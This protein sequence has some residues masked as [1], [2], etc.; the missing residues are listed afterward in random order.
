MIQEINEKIIKVL[1]VNIDNLNIEI[2]RL[3]GNYERLL[4]ERNIERNIESGSKSDSDGEQRI[5]KIMADLTEK[6][7]QNKNK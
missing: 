4:R 7:K 5:L 2:D 3:K 6:N 1:L